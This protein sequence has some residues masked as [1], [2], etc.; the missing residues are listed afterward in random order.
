MTGINRQITLD[1]KHIAKHLQNTP[2]SKRLLNRGRAAHVFIDETT[3]N[4]VARTIIEVGEFTGTIREYDRYGMFFDQPIGYRVSHD[5]TRTL[6]YYGEI[7]VNA[8]GQYHVI[9]R[10][11]SS[12]K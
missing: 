5:G 12:Q 11:G 4:S 9:P 2:Q 6:L 7:K 1:F 8:S 3:M 10:T